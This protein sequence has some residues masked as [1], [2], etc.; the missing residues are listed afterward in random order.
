MPRLQLG[1]SHGYDLQAD[2]CWKR[3]F[4]ADTTNKG[5]QL[6]QTMP[7][8]AFKDAANSA[9]AIRIIFSKGWATANSKELQSFCKSEASHETV[10]HSLHGD[11]FLDEEGVPRYG[12]SDAEH[13]HAD[14]SR[15]SREPSGPSGGD[16]VPPEAVVQPP[17]GE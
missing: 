16:S 6:N 5:I 8:G 2:C 7:P 17:G 14:P 10:G 1:V 12:P 15:G 3:Y 13:E 4:V 11:S 9:R